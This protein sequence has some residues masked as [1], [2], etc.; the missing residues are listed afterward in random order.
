MLQ[1]SDKKIPNMLHKAIFC[2]VDKKVE[3]SSF[4]LLHRVK[5]KI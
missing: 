3:Q 1:K 2:I 4:L 5:Q